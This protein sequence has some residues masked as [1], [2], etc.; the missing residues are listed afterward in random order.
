[1]MKGKL[2]LKGNVRVSGFILG[3]DVSCNGFDEID[4]V[5]SWI[6]GLVIKYPPIKGAD[7]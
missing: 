1:M 5:L 7:N 4:R 2:S 6:D 3:I